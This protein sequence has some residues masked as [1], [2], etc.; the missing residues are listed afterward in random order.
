MTAL[1]IH[2]AFTGKKLTH[3]EAMF[4]RGHKSALCAGF[5][6]QIR[7]FDTDEDAE[8]INLISSSLRSGDVHPAFEDQIKNRLKMLQ[9]KKLAARNE[10]IGD[11]K[12]G[13]EALMPDFFNETERLHFRN[14]AYKALSI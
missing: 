7:E 14:G 8:R 6:N 11:V 2:Q 10:V 13:I 9:E 1:L 12:K 5:Q 4:E 3:L